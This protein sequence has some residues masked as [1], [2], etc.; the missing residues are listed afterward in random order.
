[1]TELLERAFA[2][3]AMLTPAEQD[4]L[5]L[6]IPEDLDSDRRWD[7]SFARSAGQL[8]V[9]ADEA[10]TEHRA[11]CTKPLDPDSL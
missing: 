10:L 11:G 2:E 6:R 8:S 7:D 3:A 5:A 9:L 4:S 1:M